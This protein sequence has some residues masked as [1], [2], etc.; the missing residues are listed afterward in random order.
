MQPGRYARVHYLP[1]H[2]TGRS[3]QSDAKDSSPVERDLARPKAHGLSQIALR[4]AEVPP[5]AG[6]APSRRVGDCRPS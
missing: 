3:I 2:A 6:A 4:R 5:R 1:R